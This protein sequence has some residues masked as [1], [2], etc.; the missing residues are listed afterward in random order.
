M[1]PRKNCLI[2]DLD[3]DSLLEFN[4]QMMMGY[5]S[6]QLGEFLRSKK[7]YVTPRQVD[8][9]KRHAKLPPLEVAV[10]PSVET[11][12]PIELTQKIMRFASEEGLSTDEVQQRLLKA[13][14]E[15]TDILLE[16]FKT[17]GN[18]KLARP[19]KDFIEVS[20]SLVK[21]IQEREGQPEP[22]VTVSINLESLEASLGLPEYDQEL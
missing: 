9:H 15:A 1:A 17:F 19:L 22:Q 8:N 4:S 2:C 18:I 16:Q 21:D 5:T 6:T 13:S 10:K 12:D 11:L 3:P 14:L 20:G 7:V